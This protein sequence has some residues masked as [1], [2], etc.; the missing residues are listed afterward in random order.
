MAS[1]HQISSSEGGVPKT[2]VDE[3][4]IDINGIAGDYQANLKHHGGPDR[5]LCLY[6]LELIEKLRDEGHAIV[7]GSTGENITITGLDWK[8]LVPGTKVTIGQ[9]V[10]EI[11][12]YTSP[13]WKIVDSFADGDSSRIGQD[14]HPGWSRVYAKVIIGGTIRTGDQVGILEL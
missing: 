5:A 2:S 7:P 3:A 12:S 13:C 11:T 1:V 4:V 6:S 9:T 14:K 10:A 8:A